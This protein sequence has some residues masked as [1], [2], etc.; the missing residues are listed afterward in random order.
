MTFLAVFIT[1]YIFTYIF[2]PWVEARYDVE[3]YDGYALDDTPFALVCIPWPLWLL[4]T[5]KVMAARKG[6]KTRRTVEQQ[7]SE[8]QE[9]KRKHGLD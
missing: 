9:F 8:I 6:E 1:G 7:L 2:V 5:A 4:Y 3:L